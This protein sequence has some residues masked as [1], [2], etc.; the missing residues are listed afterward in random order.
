MYSGIPILLVY[1][2]P[3]TCNEK[4]KEKISPIMIHGGSSYILL[5]SKEMCLQAEFKMECLYFSP[6]KPIVPL[7]IVFNILQNSMKATVEICVQG[8]SL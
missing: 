6:N 1:H 3:P 2:F 4:K 5:V 7:S 8:L